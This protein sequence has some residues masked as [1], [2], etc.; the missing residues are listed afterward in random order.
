VQ[1]K[2]GTFA[3]SPF[4][5]LFG[6]WL[7]T[8]FFDALFRFCWSRNYTKAIAFVIILLSFIVVFTCAKY[9]QKNR[10]LYQ[11]FFCVRFMMF[12]QEGDK[13]NQTTKQTSTLFIL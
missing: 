3:C 9:K 7:G 5:A 2:R 8:K 6:V 1:T 12:L 11:R 10:F 13:Q 4:S